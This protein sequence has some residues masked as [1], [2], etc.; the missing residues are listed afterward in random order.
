MRSSTGFDFEPFFEVARLLYDGPWV[1]E[2]YQ[3]IRG[4]IEERPEAV[5]PPVRSIIEAGRDKSAAE[6]FAAQHKLK[7]L[8]R[9]CDQVWQSV[10][11]LLTPTAGTIYRIAEVQADPI[12][13]NSHLGHYTNHMN[14]LDYS[15]VS[16][17]AGFLADGDAAGLPWGVTW[18]APAHKDVPLLRLAD[19]FHRSL[20]VDTRGHALGATAATFALQ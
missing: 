6:L 3:A 11:C 16:V 7:A 15:A 13:L 5:F 9:V 10:D 20:S 8:K 4:F 14:L 12:R 18:S 19:R 1:A 17:P 2:R